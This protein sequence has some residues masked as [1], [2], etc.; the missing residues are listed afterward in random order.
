MIEKRIIQITIS[1]IGLIFIVS[2]LLWPGL[3]IDGITV[4][5]VVIIIV[6]W[7]APLFKS[8]ELPGGLKFEYHQLENAT[9]KLI[10]AG[11]I[12]QDDSVETSKEH[13]KYSFL[14][15]VDLDSNLALSGLRMEI[16]SRLKDLAEH[17]SISIKNKGINQLTR[18]LSTN[19][20]L[21]YIESSAIIDILPFL[22]RASHGQEVDKKIH[23][24]VIQ[25]G[26]QILDN[27]E[28]RIGEQ[29]L[30]SLI[31]SFKKRDGGQGIE[32]GY[33]LSKY[34]IKSTNSF[35]EKMKKETFR[36]WLDELENSSFTIYNA[37]DE[38]EEQL[39]HAEMSKLKEMMLNSVN[40]FL[41]ENSNNKEA[42]AL[43]E[44]LN[45]IEIKSIW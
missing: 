32:L 17:N 9:E 42:K 35:F 5:L 15:V 36:E 1:I 10:G 14:N 31:D 23:D 16:E 2:H 3:K 4:I 25:I 22:N 30:P 40:Q 39:K 12:K 41:E 19:G 20:V 37:D 43:Q 8:F 11:W 27:L 26:P 24:W 33:E 18:E 21:T 38:I 6:P 13:Y 44:K 34:L 28:A 29:K 7:L 45:K